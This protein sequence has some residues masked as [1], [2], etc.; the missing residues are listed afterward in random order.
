[1]NYTPSNIKMFV[2][3]ECDNCH[4]GCK[5]LRT[6]HRKHYCKECYRKKIEPWNKMRGKDFKRNTSGK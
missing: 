6:F 4:R 1:M 5:D 3:G 2:E